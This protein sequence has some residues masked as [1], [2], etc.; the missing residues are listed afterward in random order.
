MKY[1]ELTERIL[2]AAFEVTNELGVGFV[3]SVYENALLIALRQGGL[4]AM[5]Q[6]PLSVNFRGCL[7]G[8]FFIDVLVEETVLMELK[9]AKTLI[10]EHEMQT[11]NYLRA[12][13]LP[14]AL[15]LN[16]GAP[17]LEIRR[18]ENR[19]QKSPSSRSSL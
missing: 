4:A 11:L 18:Y 2:A 17:K 6:T 8:Q 14:V 13:G 19:F 10:P 3:E 1:A 16:F 7:V 15:L 9:A 12:S 5:Q